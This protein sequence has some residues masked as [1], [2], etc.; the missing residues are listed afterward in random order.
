MFV[1]V[2]FTGCNKQSVNVNSLPHETSSIVKSQQS[3]ISDKTI[4]RLF[5]ENKKIFNQIA[6]EL[7]NHKIY[8]ADI[9]YMSY[10]I[11]RK[12]IDITTKYP[13]LYRAI[14]D[15]YDIDKPFVVT[16]DLATIKKIKSSKS[17]TVDFEFLDL[18]HSICHTIR[19][20]NKKPDNIFIKLQDDWYYH[21]FG[22]I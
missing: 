12:E 4:K 15:Y 16:S 20:S 13:G 10:Y 17:I 14:K 7:S 2:I 11:N 18:D 5:S 6:E 1:I 9:T 3:E 19:Y 8:E 21:W 22:L